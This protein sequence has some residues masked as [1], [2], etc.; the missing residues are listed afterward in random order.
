IGFPLSGYLLSFLTQDANVLIPATQYLQISFI[1][2]IAMFIYN[3]FQSALRGVGEVKLPMFIILVAVVLNFFLDPLFMFGYGFIPAMGVPGVALATL[4]TEYLCAVIGIVVMLKGYG[5]LKVSFAHMVPRMEWLKK[6]LRL[7][8]PSSAEFSFRSFGFVLMVFVVSFFGTMA[9]AAYGIGTRIFSFVIIPAIGFALA[10]SSLIGNNL[11]SKQH[12]RA[13][14]IAKTG[15]TVAFMSLTA[16]GILLTIFAPQISAFFVPGEPE[17]ISTSAS[18]IR[19]MAWSFGLVGAQI[20]IVGTIRASGKTKTVML[21]VISNTIIQFV[22]SYVISM[23]LGYKEIGVWISY[24]I[25]TVIST[26]AAYYFY[27][28]KDWL[29]KRIV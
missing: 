7:G 15:M 8:L 13:E 28:R 26:T 12:D 18:F 22:L 23:T 27:A 29:R 14:K 4:I 10:T 11:G 9:T 5:S 24:P 21:L 1:A 2:I 20:V 19:M 16:V 25:S 3:I 17:L 6:L